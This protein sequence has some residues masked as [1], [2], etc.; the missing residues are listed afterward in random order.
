MTLDYL[1]KD[2]TNRPA[3]PN[4]FDIYRRQFGDAAATNFSALVN[5]K[6]PADQTRPVSIFWR[7][8][9][10][11]PTLCLVAGADSNLNVI[12]IYPNGFDPRITSHIFDPSISAGMQQ[13]SANGMSTS[14]TLLV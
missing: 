8:N 11:I 5:A 1:N 2:R 9:Y 7:V 13:N 12:E 3:D 14:T 10:A 4:K 6:I